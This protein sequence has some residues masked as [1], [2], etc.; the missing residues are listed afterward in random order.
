M[1][2]C[3]GVGG[4][5]EKTAKKRKERSAA[6]IAAVKGTVLDHFRPADVAGVAREAD[7]LEGKLVHFVNC[8]DHSMEAL[9]KLV[10][11]LGGKVRSPL[12]NSFHP[13]RECNRTHGTKRESVHRVQTSESHF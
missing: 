2:W 12:R 10:V 13:C 1:G 11:R 4:P 3:T 9:Q 6:A 8:G 7:F 5:Q